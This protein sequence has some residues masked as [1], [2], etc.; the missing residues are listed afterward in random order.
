MC[1]IRMERVCLLE[2]TSKRQDSDVVM[3]M[4]ME[5]KTFQGRVYILV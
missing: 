4:E 2:V 1:G 3:E 5:T